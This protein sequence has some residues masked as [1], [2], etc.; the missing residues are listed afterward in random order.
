MS[1]ELPPK[2]AVSPFPGGALGVEVI[3]ASIPAQVP[4]QGDR[5]ALRE[6]PL[7][8]PFRQSETSPERTFS[9][10]T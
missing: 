5:A 1:N 7:L 8:D 9:Q 10:A 2:D 3:F 4:W 6:I